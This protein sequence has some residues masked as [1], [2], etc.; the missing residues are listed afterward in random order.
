M[1][2][3]GMDSE[4]F[5]KP[6]SES[7]TGDSEWTFMSDSELKTGGEVANSPTDFNRMRL[8]SVEIKD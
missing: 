1:G 6:C 8:G 2:G 4:W 7:K 3:S 5:V